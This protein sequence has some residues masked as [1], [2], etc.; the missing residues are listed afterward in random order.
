M[1]HKKIRYNTAFKRTVAFV[2]SLTILAS[3]VC[4]PGIGDSIRS[5]FNAITA[6]AEVVTVRNETVRTLKEL[7]EFSERYQ[8][9]PRA[10]SRTNLTIRF[11]DNEISST[12][13]FDG[14]D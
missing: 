6:S 7:Y 14:V 4:F 8:L 11:D 3:S 2:T 13:T 5:V 9:N 10:Y 12:K 1:K